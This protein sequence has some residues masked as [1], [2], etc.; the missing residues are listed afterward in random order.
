M[1]YTLSINHLV[2]I[3]PQGRKLRSSIREVQAEAELG[4]TALSGFPGSFFGKLVNVSPQ[5]IHSFKFNRE[6]E[7]SFRGSTYTFEELEQD[8]S[9]KLRRGDLV[10]K[11]ITDKIS[12]EQ[13]ATVKF[14]AAYQEMLGQLRRPGF[15]RVLCAHEA[16]H[17]Y[18]FRKMGITQYQPYPAEILY[19]ASLDDYGGNLAS[20]KAIDPPLSNDEVEIQARLTLLSRALAAGGVI[21]RKLDPTTEGGDGDDKDRFKVMCD[22]FNAQDSEKLWKQAQQEVLEDLSHPEVMQEIAETGLKLKREFGL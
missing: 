2:S 22:L 15:I 18:Y 16:A 21:A 19:N 11:I 7:V 8:G 6:V 9:F 10:P 20:V 3:D 12:V 14:K 4:L 1:L 13:K 5:Q 17:L